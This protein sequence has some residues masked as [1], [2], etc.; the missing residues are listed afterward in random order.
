MTAASAPVDARG[1]PDASA[2]GAGRETQA[3]QAKPRRRTPLLLA[4]L[5]AV[6]LAASGGWYLLTRGSGSRP[7]VR[8]GRGEGDERFG[9]GRGA[10]PSRARHGQP[11]RERGRRFGG[12][13]PGRLCGE[14]GRRAG[15][16][17]GGPGLGRRGARSTRGDRED[18]PGDS[19]SKPAEGSSPPLR[20]RSRPRPRSRKQKQISPQPNREGGS[21]N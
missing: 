14:G 12:A 9:P 1:E 7:T 16:P 15:R 11:G 5:A 18:G 17:R 3:T 20:R 4:S 8:A 13:R 10:R 21:P 6:A 19:S 2:A